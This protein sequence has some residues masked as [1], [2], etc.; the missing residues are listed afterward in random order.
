[1]AKHLE[2]LEL[3]QELAREGQQLMTPF[4]RSAQT[5]TRNSI[6]ELLH[7]TGQGIMYVTAGALLLGMLALCAGNVGWEWI[8]EKLT[9]KAPSP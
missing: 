8:Q 5:N 1:M 7:K 3:E 4:V 9:G 2:H 6:Q